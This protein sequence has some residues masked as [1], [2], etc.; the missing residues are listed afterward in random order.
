MADKD[1][2]IWPM[3]RLLD[4]I[5]DADAWHARAAEI[6]DTFM[7]TLGPTPPSQY[8]RGFEADPP[9]RDGDVTRTLLRIT[10]DDDDVM[11]AWLIE[12]AGRDPVGVA[13]APHGTNEHGKD[14]V[15]AATSTQ[16]KPYGLELAQR[17][18]IVLAPDAHALCNR[19]AKGLKPYDTARFY[20]RFPG[21][22]SVGKIIIDLR[23]CLD[24]L[25]QLPQTKGRP[26]DAIGH[27]LGAQSAIYVAAADQ[28]VRSC[29]CNCGIYP[30][31]DSR[32]R[33][34]WFR[35]AW[36]IYYRDAELKQSVLNGPQPLWDFHEVAALLAPRRLLISVAPNDYCCGDFGGITHMA[37]D[38][39]RVWSLLDAPCNLTCVMHNDGHAFDRRHRVF[40]Y[41]W[42]EAADDPIPDGLKQTTEDHNPN[43]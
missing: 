28:R 9:Q 18:W 42:L 31:A 36:Y 17:G 29:V 11:E 1:F 22:S 20:E 24:V 38:L 13:L 32:A 43:R 15:A 27:S 26:V 5:G 14:Y 25:E 35:D 7:R 4:G 40:A 23:A 30:F 37:E 19:Y 21:W 6:R 12:P 33:A 39:H 8:L 16:H 34:H 10:V 2:P 41:E 3:R